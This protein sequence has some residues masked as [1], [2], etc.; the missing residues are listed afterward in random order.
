MQ[1]LLGHTAAAAKCKALA[2]KRA[3]N[4]QETRSQEAVANKRLT[5]VTETARVF[6]QQ[7][8][9]SHTQNCIDGNNN[10]NNA[11]HLFVEPVPSPG[12]S[13]SHRQRMNKNHLQMQQPTLH[14]GGAQ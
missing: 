13:E 1:M 9:K 5:D 12:K 8:L 7:M 3:A 2:G 10:V 14:G 4:Q 11:T 6:T